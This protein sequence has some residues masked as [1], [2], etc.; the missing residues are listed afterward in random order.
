[1]QFQHKLVVL[2]KRNRHP[3][4]II[5]H[6]LP[7]FLVFL[8]RLFKAVQRLRAPSFEG[9]VRLRVHV[10][11]KIVSVVALV[12]FRLFDQ[13]LDLRRSICTPRIRAGRIDARAVRVQAD[14]KLPEAVPMRQDTEIFVERVLV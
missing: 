6:S 2:V 12:K 4:R 13:T 5:Q 10:I 14:R 1:M 3:V 11:V 9:L 8:Q 7:S